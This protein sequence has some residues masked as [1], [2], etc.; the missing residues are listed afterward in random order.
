LIKEIA[1]LNAESVSPQK[2]EFLSAHL[3]NWDNIDFDDWRQVA[4]IIL[5][6]V[7]TLRRTVCRLSGKSDFLP[8][9]PYSIVCLPLSSDASGSI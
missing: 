7:S 8:P 3:G 5:F 6:Q 1:A 9:A 2:I 4:D